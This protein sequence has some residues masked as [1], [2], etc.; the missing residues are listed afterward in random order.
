[1]LCEWVE[2]FEWYVGLNGI[3]ST[4]F[5]SAWMDHLEKNYAVILLNWH[6]L[7]C[8]VQI[9]EWDDFDYYLTARNF[10]DVEHNWT[11]FASPRSQS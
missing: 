4:P 3:K 1:M 10:N 6:N 9:S 11:V 8:F 7:A 2:E 5:V